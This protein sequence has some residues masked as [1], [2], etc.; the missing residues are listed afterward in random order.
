MEGV[1]SLSNRILLIEPLQQCRGGGGSAHLCTRYHIDEDVA[2]FLWCFAAYEWKIAR[3]IAG[4]PGLRPLRP[5]IQT[6]GWVAGL[7]LGGCAFET[8]ID[9]I[10][11]E[12]G[13]Q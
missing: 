3:R 9:E 4:R 13:N 8:R 12:I 6:V 11:G 1:C 7:H 5:L 2:R 10:A